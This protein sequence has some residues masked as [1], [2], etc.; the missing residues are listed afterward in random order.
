MRIV[1]HQVKNM[2]NLT[3][4]EQLAYSTVRIE[5]VLEDGISTGTGFFFRFNEEDDGSHIPVIVTN[6]HVI[7]DSK[8]G[9]FQLTLKDDSGDPLLEHITFELGE[10]ESRW[11]HHP[12]NEIDLCVMPIAPLLHMAK[13]Y[14]KEFYFLS[15][16]QDLLPNED[17]FDDMFGMD[18]IT[19]VG[20]PIGIW[21]STH[22]L[23][24][25]RRGITATNPKYDWNGRKEFL[26][27]CACFPG[28]SGSP[29]L[30]Y[31]V[32]G[33]F[34]RKGM[35]LGGSRIKLLG[36]LYAGPQYT[37]TGE[38]EIVNVPVKQ[39]PVAKSNIPSNLGIVIKSEKLLDFDG[40]FNDA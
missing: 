17:D 10:F 21:D 30:L 31:N 14:D 5:A 12:E 9:R 28:S 8:T 19:M 4:I 3:P 37:A 20:Y 11:I 25:F 23:P 7:E 1:R 33:Y 36:V 24:V 29:V 6:K 18:D 32:G 13:E 27:D 2:K 22:N 39:Q 15:L 16:G 40:I 38:I 26:I 34:T 35:Q